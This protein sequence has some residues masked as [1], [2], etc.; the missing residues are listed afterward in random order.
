MVGTLPRA[1]SRHG[2]VGSG[3]AI[4]ARSQYLV[5]HL[6][7]TICALPIDGIQ[8]VVALPALSRPP[9]LPSVLEG[10][11]NLGGNAV[12]VLRLDRLFGLEEVG[13]GLYTPLL[14]LHQPEDQ[15]A[16]LVESVQGIVPVQPADVRLVNGGDSFNDCVEGEITLGDRVVHLLSSE[17]LLLEKERQCLA[18]LQAVEQERLRSMQEARP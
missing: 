7:G 12:P 14:V 16:L 17:R 18:E 2:A 6:P 11:L 5:F 4:R 15:I 8:E 1:A 10:F 3:A 9:S 13:P